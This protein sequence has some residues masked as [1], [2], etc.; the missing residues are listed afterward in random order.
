MAIHVPPSLRKRAPVRS[1]N[2][3][4]EAALSV[5]TRPRS[6]V[7]WPLAAS[8]SAARDINKLWVWVARPCGLVHAVCNVA[9][10]PWHRIRRAAIKWPLSY[11]SKMIASL[12]INWAKA[13]MRPVGSARNFRIWASLTLWSNNGWPDPSH[14]ISHTFK[15]LVLARRNWLRHF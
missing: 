15:L 12:G 4:R 2:R 8:R 6:K 1:L 9:V 10:G 5:S 14:A 13:A 7:V 11:H 3:A